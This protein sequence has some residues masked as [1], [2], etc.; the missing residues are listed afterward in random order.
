MA[1]QEWQ[2]VTQDYGV[3]SFSAAPA[4]TVRPT[5]QGIEVIV[6]YITRANERFALRSRLYHAAVQM[7]HGKKIEP[8]AV[9]SAADSE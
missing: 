8:L 4:I 2:R 7:L 9:P 3:Q 1:E 6:R 5:S